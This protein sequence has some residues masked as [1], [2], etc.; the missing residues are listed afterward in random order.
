MGVRHG[1]RTAKGSSCRLKSSQS[2]TGQ[3]Q[4]L[5]AAD[6]PDEI[7]V[8]HG[9]AQAVGDSSQQLVA[10]GVPVLVVD[11]LEVVQVDEQHGAFGA[12]LAA[13]RCGP[14]AR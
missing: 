12:A 6:A 7:L 5:V 2:A 10:D 9:C 11:L 13:L 4:E 14:P 1:L 3:N 8:S